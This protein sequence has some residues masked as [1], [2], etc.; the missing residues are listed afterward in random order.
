M[1]FGKH[2]GSTDTQ[3]LND[4]DRL[5]CKSP[6][7][8]LEVCV[9]FRTNLSFCPRLPSSRVRMAS[10][11]IFLATLSLC[12]VQLITLGKS[13]G[14]IQLL[15]RPPESHCHIAR[16]VMV[17]LSTLLL[18]SPS[19]CELEEDRTAISLCA[20]VPARPCTKSSPGIC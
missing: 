16:H 12:H 13:S 17:C 9:V 4:R 6:P 7:G 8:M 2:E 19:G 1:F 3:S 18:L 20:P 11:P 10:A 5:G 14:P 15:S